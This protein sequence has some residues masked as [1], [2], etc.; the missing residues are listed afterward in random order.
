MEAHFLLQYT[1]M[2]EQGPKPN[3]LSPIMKELLERI[4]RRGLKEAGIDAA[5]EDNLTSDED[6]EEKLIQGL[7]NHTIEERNNRE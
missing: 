4:S 1:Q 7:P 2:S 6:H 3:D 5:R